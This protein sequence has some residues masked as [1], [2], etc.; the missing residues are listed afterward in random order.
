MYE[1]IFRSALRWFFISMA[2]VAGFMLGLFVLFIFMAS[3]MDLMQTTAGGEPDIKYSFS[4]EILPNA[5]G[6]RKSLSSSAPVILRVNIQGVIGLEDLTHEKLEQLL[7]ESRERSFSDNRVKA[8]LLYINT[9]GGTVVDAD[10]IYRA[11][12]DYKEMYKV[13]IYA[14]VDGLCASGGMYVACAADK[15]YATEGSIVGSIGVIVSSS[16]NVSKLMDKIGVES[17]TMFAGKGKDEL[18]PLRP[19]TPDEG[20]NFQK[21]IDE[22][23]SIF[24]DIVTKNRPELSKEKLVKD[25]GANVFLANQAKEY[26]YI[27]VT[28]IS[29][30]DTLTLLAK[31]I[32]IDDDYYQ[33]VELKEENWLRSLF[34]GNADLSLFKGEIKHRLVIQSDLDPKLANQFLYLYRPE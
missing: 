11:L 31:Q 28:G 30:N 33:V 4:P 10:G 21:L 29:M 23:Y 27:D 5:K 6:I 13:P 16:V 15:I 8:I 3:I 17:K 14:Y 25:Y 2:A 12:K 34:K 22:Y 24:V 7:T 26:G 1:S 32:G 18:N 19:W 9:P 20:E